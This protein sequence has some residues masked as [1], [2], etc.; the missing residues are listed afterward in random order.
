MAAL[1]SAETRQHAP[2]R[3]GEWL[4]DIERLLIRNESQEISLEPRVMELLVYLSEHPNE[5][6]SAEQLLLDIWHGTFYG[7][8]PVQRAIAILRRC[9]GDDALS[10]RYIETIRKR[11]YRLIAD[12]VLPDNYAASLGKGMPSWAA[13]SPFVG[14]QAF[15]APHSD[16]FFGRARSTAALLTAM[17]M[18]WRNGHR[19]VLLLGLS[20]CGKTS[21]IQAGVLPLLTRESG[22][23]GLHAVAVA[24]ADFAHTGQGD[25]LSVL[26]GAL[27]Q[28]TLGIRPIFMD[29]S[30]VD[31]QLRTDPE[32]LLEGLESAFARWPLRSDRPT[33]LL[34]LV[35]DHT[36]AA[37]AASSEHCAL[38]N[39]ALLALCASPRLLL[40]M[41]CRSDFY[42]ALLSQLP[43]IVGL[44]TPD[45]HFDLLPPT[46]GELA[47]IIRRPAQAAGLRFEKNPLTSLGLDDVLRDAAV[48]HPEALAMLQYTL[49]ALYDARAEGYLLSFAAYD[50]LGGLGGA[51]ALRA[52]QM[53]QELPADAQAAWVPVFEQLVISHESNQA[54]TARRLPW[55]ALSSRAERDLVQRLVDARLFTSSL[56]DDRAHFSV[57]HETLLRA[58]PR[59][60]E[61]AHDNQRQL[62]A[63]RRVKQ[64]TLRWLQAD[65]RSDFLLNYGLPLLE[66]NDLL[67]H[68]PRLLDGDD[69]SLI[70]A[71][72]ASDRRRRRRRLLAF[73]GALLLAAVSAFSAVWA[74]RAHQDAERRRSQA[75]SLVDYLLT[76]LAE[77]LRPLG[78]LAL[79]DH[80]AQRALGFLSNLP[81]R[82][83]DENTRIQRVRALR[84][85]GEVFVER[86]NQ[87]AA[88]RAFSQAAT[89]LDEASSVTSASSALILERGTVAYWQGMLAFRQNAL[90]EAEKHF[91][92]YR[93]FASVLAQ[94]EPENMDWQLEL[95]YAL[96]NLGSLAQRRQ[97]TEQALALFQQSVALKDRVLA[98]TPENSALAVE[99]A[100]SLSWI[101]S[102][103][104]RLGRLPEA[105]DYYER[106]LQVL[107]GVGARE[108]AA[109]GWRHRLAL[110][111]LIMGDLQI[112]MGNLSAAQALNE[113]AKTTLT[114]LVAVD[115]SNTTWQ[116]DLSYAQTQAAY[117]LLIEKQPLHALEYLRRA[118][119]RLRPLLV[120]VEA[121]TNW[122]LLA[123]EISLRRAQATY[124]SASTYAGN[125][126]LNEAMAGAQA[127]LG[128]NADDI[129]ALTLM[130]RTLLV[131]GDM[132]SAQG[133][134]QKAQSDWRRAQ[135]LLADN[136]A[137]SSNWRVLQ[138]WIA[139]HQRLSLTENMV[140]YQE[141]LQKSGYRLSEQAPL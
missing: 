38:F 6:I 62:Q 108:P 26:A 107:R 140:S 133:Q 102:T 21:L 116:R 8:G 29:R 54:L 126:F 128:R 58:W 80:V 79:M 19:L 41:L 131:R 76:D 111:E 101:G 130:A 17:G 136:A 33:P 11:G 49:Q 114:Q 50:A 24:R 82:D 117:L 7:D 4:V 86:G 69:Q 93:I 31:T 46:A 10:P 87:S 3:V 59:V 20:G 60:Q 105:A 52:E 119:E 66:A 135:T 48:A 98:K 45:G 99:Q 88:A 61:W 14:L 32:R 125:A 13:G 127:L 90:D 34:L 27:C 35:L 40:V 63:Q 2:M 106:Q 129:N 112:A 122:R 43:A 51:L 85:L 28:W 91:E 96:N 118:E 12:V 36:E 57:T 95:S 15:D 109:D 67:Q 18:Q 137:Q 5:V 22:F 72:V 23:D 89:L 55:S 77:E 53:F 64:A 44:K 138:P 68:A 73:C 78:R 9:L 100:D 121:P 123:V 47:E 42:P 94:R 139:I 110:A 16:V 65:R 115:V 104:D 70:L 30:D 71:S 92:R 37:L 132:L 1:S 25:A 83:T 124:A 97:Q 81:E 39:R 113:T 141:R 134:T 84:T 56:N 120:D 74:V 75:E 103:L